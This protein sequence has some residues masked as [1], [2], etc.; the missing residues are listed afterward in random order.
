MELTF[1]IYVNFDYT[2]VRTTAL[3]GSTPSST[4]IELRRPIDGF[5]ELGQRAKWWCV[6]LTNAENVGGSCKINS[7]TLYHD[8][9][10]I[11]GKIYGN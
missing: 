3:T 4:D 9:T 11:K 6:E 5:A 1:N 8:P 7:L 2:V 10:D